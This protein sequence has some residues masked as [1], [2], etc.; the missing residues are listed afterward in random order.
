MEEFYKMILA[1][2]KLKLIV[3]RTRLEVF[4]GGGTISSVKNQAC[5]ILTASHRI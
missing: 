5:K 2:L 1:A 3:T 4:I